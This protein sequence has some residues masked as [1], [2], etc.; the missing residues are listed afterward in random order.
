MLIDTRY[1]VGTVNQFVALVAMFLAAC[2]I[3]L[4]LH[5]GQFVACK[6]IHSPDAFFL[7]HECLAVR[8]LTPIEIIIA[9][10]VAQS[11]AQKLREILCFA[12]SI[13]HQL[14]T[15]QKVCFNNRILVQKVLS[16][17]FYLLQFQANIRC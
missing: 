16:F 10:L 15:K 6:H 4:C 8:A 1:L 5:Q 17:V 9:E 3:G 14:C 11:S 13:V 2:K 7:I 12:I